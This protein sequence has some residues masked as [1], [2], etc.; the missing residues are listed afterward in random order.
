MPGTVPGAGDS[1]R[2]EKEILDLR[3][4]QA[5]RGT[6]QTGGQLAATMQRAGK[7]LSVHAAL[8]A[9]GEVGLGRP[10]AQF[11]SGVEG[12]G[13]ACAQ[14]LILGDRFGNAMTITDFYCAAP[15]PQVLLRSVRITLI[16]EVETIIISAL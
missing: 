5:G 11:C 8:G 12:E 2:T 13:P 14:R 4:S 15:M 10:Q 6:G 1:K 7:Y 9:Q 3:D 16:P